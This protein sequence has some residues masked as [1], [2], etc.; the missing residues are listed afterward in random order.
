MSEIIVKRVE[1]PEELNALFRLRYKMYCEELHWLDAANYPEGIEKDEYDQ[2]SLHYGVFKGRDAIGTVRLIPENPCGFPII[3]VVGGGIIS[4]GERKTV[5]VSRLLV[6]KASNL[7][8]YNTITIVI[9][10]IKQ[11]YFDGKYKSGVTDWFA[12]LDVYVYRLIRMIGFKFKPLGVPKIYMGSKTVPAYITTREAD[13][14]LLNRNKS[15]YDYL[16]SEND[17]FF[18]A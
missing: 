10:L 6:D 2:Y 5:E 8:K 17:I 16:N 4:S 3:N 7:T 18:Q 9:A 11:V 14:Y 13:E 1:D 15:F 12:A